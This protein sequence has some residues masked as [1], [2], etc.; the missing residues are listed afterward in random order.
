MPPKHKSLK[1]HH[2][3]GKMC[4]CQKNPRVILQPFSA[5]DA[6]APSN[7]PS[8]NSMP[9][10]ASLYNKKEWSDIKLK[11]GDT[12]YHAHRL[13]LCAGS[14]VFA[15]MLGSDWAESKSSILELHEEHE[16]V[17]VFERFLFYLYTGQVA[18]S[19]ACVIP[20]FLLADKYTVEALYD[21]CVKVIK[22]GLKVY[23]VPPKHHPHD[24]YQLSSS[25]PSS[26]DSSES[27]D[28][29][30][31]ED[32]V[33]N[34][35]EAGDSSPSAS[36]IVVHMAESPRATTSCSAKVHLFASEI[37]PLSLVMKMLTFCQNESIRS[38]ALYNLEVRLS[39]QIR[40]G[41]FGVW[42]DLDKELLL[43]MLGDDNF[44][45]DEF[46][47][48]RA[49]TSWLCYQE[50][51]QTEDNVTEVLSMIR[52]PLLSPRQLYEVE[53][54]L[55]ASCCDDAMLLI[56]SAMRYRLFKDCVK[57]EK[58]DW[59]GTQFQSRRLRSDKL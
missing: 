50:D 32:E 37:F 48:F 19:E 51:R 14:E 4:G 30:A 46:T 5:Y 35:P 6:R 36:A 11:V 26:S 57:G 58:E 12:E 9:P 27:E 38:S 34:S 18:I 1:G 22:N 45:C 33:V 40:H 3:D 8:F 24:P 42:N 55:L 7:R 13:V 21:E 39:N 47:L 54:D 43:H 44:Y 49:S 17:K 10:I 23:V 41:Y 16:C 28:V 31:P 20:L 29:S 59:S 2:C 15:R 25:S 52:Y 53:K 56:R